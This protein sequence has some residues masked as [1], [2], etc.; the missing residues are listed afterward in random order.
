M[1]E[2]SGAVKST[3]ETRFG[4][5]GRN[6]DPGLT[7]RSFVGVKPRGRKALLAGLTDVLTGELTGF[8]GVNEGNGG[9]AEDVRP[10]E[11]AFRSSI[12]GFSGGKDV[13]EGAGCVFETGG[14]AGADR[15]SVSGSE[16]FDMTGK[17]GAGFREVRVEFS[18]KI[19]LWCKFDRFSWC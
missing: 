4:G 3:L 17:P 13:I 16:V 6:A 9:A 11:M 2:G 1:F 15:F 8:R 19:G 5:I 10:V 7:G 12:G 14:A 18:G